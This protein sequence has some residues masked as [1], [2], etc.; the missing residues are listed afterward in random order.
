M[1]SNPLHPPSSPADAA[2]D[3]LVLVG[4]LRSR[5]WLESAARAT[6]A[7]FFT[8]DLRDGRIT[9]L[10]ARLRAMLALGPDQ[11][12]DAQ[13]LDL[14]VASGDRQQLETCVREAAESDG[15][16]TARLRL[17]GGQSTRDLELRATLERDAQGE[18]FAVS[19][20]LIDVTEQIELRRRVRDSQARFRTLMAT[21]LVNVLMVRADGT[22]VGHNEQVCRYLGWDRGSL[23]GLHLAA[24]DATG[25]LAALVQGRDGQAPAGPVETQVLTR[26][27]AARDVLVSAQYLD[28]DGA[29]C[30]LL[31]WVDLS[32]HRSS[33]RDVVEQQQRLR[34]ALISGRMGTWEWEP[35]TGRTQ[36]NEAMYL[37]TGLP[38]GEP[39]DAAGFLA[40]VVPEDRPGL[41]AYL[42][43]LLEHGTDYEAEFRV[44]RPDGEVRWLAGKGAVM[45]DADGV[46]RA[47]IG[48]NFDV[49]DRR[50]A[51]AKLQEAD[52]RKDEWLAML[53]HELR[54]PLAPMVNAVRLLQRGPLEAAQA[55]AVRLIDRQLAH[56]S[57][58]VGDLLDA[59]RLTRGHITLRRRPT[60]IADA[61]D[62]AIES[63]RPLIEARQQR[64][65]VVTEG[66]PRP[67]DADPTRLAQVFTN[68][69]HNASKYSGAGDAIS[70]RVVEGEDSVRVELRDPG[71]GIAPELLPRVFDLFTQAEMSLERAPG[72]LGIGL[73]LVKSLVELHGGSVEAASEGSGRGACFAVTL[74]RRLA[75]G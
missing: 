4:P 19:G 24:F 35:A 64:V 38:P 28:F 21:T 40:L 1:S 45:R 55:M 57:H 70:I 34:A 47:M 49:T 9:A 56:V 61:I 42:A 3:P 36:W 32:R 44:R 74:P 53:A 51:L 17:T 29:P 5:A 12:P 68:L 15:L 37:L 16:I 50:A 13:W 69:L 18:P 20:A 23:D 11:L 54:N 52:R 75:A 63:V 33:E 67:I 27:G 62:S 72:G 10:D 46:V 7:G 8:W 22:I 31:V 73:A 39:V 60:E 30:A 58:L 14:N 26:D 59:S 25:L 71:E 48:V 65:T 6:G 41:E 2:A 43:R 66:Q